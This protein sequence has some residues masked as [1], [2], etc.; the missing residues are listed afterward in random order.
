V[1]TELS[2]ADIERALRRLTEWNGDHTAISRTVQLPP[3]RHQPLVERIQR[4]AREYNDHATVHR[5]GDT[6]TVTLST[7]RDGVVTRPDLDLAERIDDV[8]AEV[9]SGG[10]PD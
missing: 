6:I 3:D 8:V 4:E 1:P 9:G 2:D 5:D 7:G 10:R